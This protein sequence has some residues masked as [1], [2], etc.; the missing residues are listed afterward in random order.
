MGMLRDPQSQRIPHDTGHRK[1]SSTLSSVRPRLPPEGSYSYCN[2]NY[3]LLGMII[4]KITGKSV[5]SQ[6]RQRIL[7]P[8]SLDHT[9]LEVEEPYTDP[10]AHPWDSGRDFASTPVTA[11]FTTLW[12][13][14]GIMSTAENMARWVT[15]LYEGKVIS[16]AALAQIVDSR[17][18]VVDRYHRSGVERLRVG[19]AAGIVLWKEDL[20][21][22][23]RGHG[24]RVYYRICS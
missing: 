9:Y 20:W 24:L 7:T 23:G 6:I 16:Q 13:A 19:S 1:R 12:T 2:T 8:L 4:Q 14:G 5:S 10:V 17:P 21:T 11:H 3:V 15:G 22:R 18:H